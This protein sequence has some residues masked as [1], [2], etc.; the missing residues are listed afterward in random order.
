MRM[1]AR[2]GVLHRLA[3]I[4]AFRDK[5]L[6]QNSQGAGRLQNLREWTPYMC[7]FLNTTLLGPVDIYIVEQ[8]QAGPFNKGGLFNVGYHMALERDS[9][10]FVFHD[11]DHVPEN[12]LNT[13]EYSS[14]ATHLC[15]RTS[16]FGYRDTHGGSL[17]GA[18]LM[19]RHV[20]SSI[21][22]YSNNFWGWG[23]EDDDINARLKHHGH[24]VKKLPPD[25]GRY[26]A[27]KHS[28][29]K[30]LDK[31]GLYASHPVS[32]VTSGISDVAWAVRK[33]RISKHGDVWVHRILV[34]L[35]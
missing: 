29:T 27:L 35:L 24:S 30:G 5:P 9:D 10:Y 33:R 23:G 15:A 17:G 28:R 18:L 25:V 19:P 8:T 3:I 31:T 21:N 32:D 12:P 26:R 2:V 4:V 13:Y 1:G 20:V 22:G 16:Q 6:D 14:E 11:V 7:N 34:K